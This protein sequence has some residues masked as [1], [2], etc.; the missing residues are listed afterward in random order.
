MF[1]GASVPLPYFCLTSTY[2]Y[3]VP[4]HLHSTSNYYSLNIYDRYNSD[5]H[6]NYHVRTQ[7]IP[8]TSICKLIFRLLPG[9]YIPFHLS[10]FQSSHV[11]RIFTET[12]IRVCRSLHTLPYQG[13][14]VSLPPTST[15]SHLLASTSIRLTTEMCG[16]YPRGKL[17][18]TF[19][20]A[21]I[22]SYMQRDLRLLPR[23]CIHFHQTSIAP[24]Y[25]PHFPFN[26]SFHGNVQVGA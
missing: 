6:G 3:V 1:T 17:P 22:H 7:T 15:Y 18:S 8:S 5:C 11:T 20:D 4:T 16:F 19:A 2:F 12:Y 9:T 13:M 23:T 26:L 21:S 14:H 10:N 24:I 25:L